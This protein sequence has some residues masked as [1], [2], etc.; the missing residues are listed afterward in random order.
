MTRER[1]TRSIGALLILTVVFAGGFCLAQARC[2]STPRTA[3]PPLSQ[4]VGEFR[5]WVN[6]RGYSVSRTDAVSYRTVLDI[7]NTAISKGPVEVHAEQGGCYI[8]RVIYEDDVSFDYMVSPEYLI[9]PS[10]SYRIEGV[11]LLGVFEGRGKPTE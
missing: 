6:G 5:A 1:T 4:S 3:L 8:V 7:V 9:T 10:G 2:N 11:M